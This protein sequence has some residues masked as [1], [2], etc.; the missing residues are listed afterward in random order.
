MA[1]KVVDASAI[2]ALLFG[3]TEAEMV[4]RLTDDHELVAPSLISFELANV[5]TTKI[6]RDPKNRDG[7]LDGF[8]RLYA[9]AISERP[10]DHSGVLRLA[11][12][13]RLSA[14]DA[15][16]LWLAREM[17]VELVTLDKRLAAAAA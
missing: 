11:E 10:V 7:L 2:A 9:L 1:V 3:E 16:Y 15:S 4:F 13:H 5:C 6:R 12:A 14:Y 17:N 8:Q